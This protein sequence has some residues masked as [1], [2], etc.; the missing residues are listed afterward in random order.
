MMDEF[1]AL[2][3][4]VRFRGD[5]PP[6]DETPD[7]SRR[8]AEFAARMRSEGLRVTEILTPKIYSAVVGVSTR[9][10]LDTTPEVFVV[11]DPKPNAAVPCLGRRQ[12]PLIILKSGLVQ[13]LNPLQLQFVLGHELGHFGL[14]HT[15]VAGDQSPQSE[16]EHLRR[17]S[18]QRCSEIGADRVGL[19]AT[20]SLFTCAMVMVKLISGLSETH[21]RLDVQAFLD[22]LQ[23]PDGDYD[24]RWELLTTHPSLPLRLRALIA[25]GQSDVYSRLNGTGGGGRSLPEV[26]AEVQGLLDELGDGW[27]SSLETQTIDLA[28]AWM[29]VSL[30][31]EDGIVTQV[32]RH[33]LDSLVGEELAAKALNFGKDLGLDAVH[34]KLAAAT[35][36]LAGG[37]QRARRRLARVFDA[38]TNHLG[39]QAEETVTWKALPPWLRKDVTGAR[40]GT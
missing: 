30:V 40:Q 36:G 33:V 8:S 29:G 13:L 22:Q 18:A 32:E 23:S 14:G 15:S 34:E 21:V 5:V 25:F 17:M 31:L 1:L 9:L 37:E 10:Q 2:C 7:H 19:I 12:R 35:D 6:E 4:S 16:Y 39:M 11:E 38:F 27:L 28:A 3:G 24:R 20:R 26:D